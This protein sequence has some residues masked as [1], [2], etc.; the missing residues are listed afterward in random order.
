MVKYREVCGSG[1]TLIGFAEAALDKA[2]AYAA[3]CA[4][5]TLRLHPLF[6]R[7][8]VREK[9]TGFY[10]TVERPLPRIVAEMEG[11]GIKV[12]R[13]ALNALSGDFAARMAELERQAYIHPR[14]EFNLGPPKQLRDLHPGELDLPGGKKG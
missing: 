7:R 1:K 6:K 14:H 12:G 5:V 4:D 10:E 11:A 3:E 13:A 9:M 2:L 8:L